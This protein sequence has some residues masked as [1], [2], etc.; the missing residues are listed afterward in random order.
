MS[1]ESSL[2]LG[3]ERIAKF[4]LRFRNSSSRLI[5]MKITR[6]MIDKKMIDKNMIIVM[7]ITSIVN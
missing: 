7:V 5:L 2:F 4:S 3:I 1:S 6:Q